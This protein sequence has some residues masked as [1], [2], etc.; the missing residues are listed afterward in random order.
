M[1]QNVKREKKVT[2][3]KE[4]RT[5]K[6][7]KIGKHREKCEKLREKNVKNCS[8]EKIKNKCCKI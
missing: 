7:C 1:L 3:Q 4:K 6:G 8:E 2:A 5:K